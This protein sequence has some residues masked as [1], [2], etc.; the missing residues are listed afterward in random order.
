MKTNSFLDNIHVKYELSLSL[1]LSFFFFRI[2]MKV[3][4]TP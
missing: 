1:S 2:D 3:Y 4:E